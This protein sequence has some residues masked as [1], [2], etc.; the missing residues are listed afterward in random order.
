MEPT[1]KNKKIPSADVITEI[2]S[3]AFHGTPSFGSSVN[4]NLF[5]QSYANILLKALSKQKITPQ[6]L[7]IC[8]RL[9]LM[10]E[11]EPISAVVFIG[12]NMK[13]KDIFPLT[14]RYTALF[15]EMSELL[16]RHCKRTKT[17]RCAVIYRRTR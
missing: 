9:F 17:R 15:S 5:S 14:R 7:E 2:V 16:I 11:K 4:E 13:I 6:S 12:N 8:A 3:S 10:F 1:S